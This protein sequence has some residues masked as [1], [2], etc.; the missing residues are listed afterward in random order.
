MKIF[1]IVFCITGFIFAVEFQVYSKE[2]NCDSNK[3]SEIFMKMQA[4][5]YGGAFDEKSF[6]EFSK[7]SKFGYPVYEQIKKHSNQNII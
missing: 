6:R 2:F 4:S 5:L 1:R 7:F 3:M